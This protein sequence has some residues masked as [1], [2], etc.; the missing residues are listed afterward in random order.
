MIVNAAN[1]ASLTCADVQTRLQSALGATHALFNNMPTTGTF[2]IGS[3][4]GD[5][6]SF[7]D[8]VLTQFESNGTY[9]N[10]ATWDRWGSGL[11]R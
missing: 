4:N 6:L 3:C 7:R 1:A 5:Q 2:I 9:Y 8:E 11:P 10:R